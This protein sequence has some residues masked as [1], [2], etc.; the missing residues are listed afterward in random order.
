MNGPGLP[1]VLALFDLV[2]LAGAS[3]GPA[4]SLATTMGPMIAAAGDLAPLALV[5]LTGVMTLAAIAFARMLL[6]MPD[7]GSS[8]SWIRSAFGTGAGAYGAWLL[9]LSNLFAVL[10]TALPAGMY[11]LDLFAPRLAGSP[12]WI[13]AIGSVWILASAVVLWLGLRP[14]SRVAAILLLGEL[15]VLVATAA[16]ASTKAPAAAVEH[17][18]GH[19]SIGGIVVAM[20]I[21]IWMT[22]G[23]EVTASASEEVAGK[24][25]AAGRGGIIGLLV[26]AAFLLACMIAYMRVGTVAGF[27]EHTED[28]LAYVG[29][30]LG[31]GAWSVAI[32][33]TVLISLMASLQA[34]VV[35]LSRSVYAMGRDGV[36]PAAIGRLDRRGTP[37]A[38]IVLVTLVVLGFTLSTGLSKSARDAYDVVLNGSAIF[39]GA[40]FMFSTAA[41]ARTFL[42][43]VRARLTGV[44]VPL[45]AT[46]LLGAILVA[47]VLQSDL[48]T[49]LFIVTGTLA[50]L[51]LA[52]WRSRRS[53]P[54]HMGTTAAG[55]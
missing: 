30:Q 3:M 43:D 35:Y 8:Y 26:T 34:T 14:T 10:A 54:R 1:R 27:S 20:A 19:A 40:L 52:A 7:A 12:L 9:L 24:R 45:C 49:R 11:T 47:A 50:G 31:G 16:V 28:S 18:P 41:V 48:P 46:V 15:V 23:W 55:P 17:A 29:A 4:F 13:A 53:L 39:L 33:A 21:G 6:V 38:S 22:D 44:V 32:E 51:P 2:V 36:L 25:N 42:R 5:L 37:A